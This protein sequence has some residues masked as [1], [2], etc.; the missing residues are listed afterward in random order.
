MLPEPCASCSVLVC[1]LLLSLVSFLSKINECMYVCIYFETSNWKALRLN[2]VLRNFRSVLHSSI[3]Q[4]SIKTKQIAD[5]Q[6]QYVR[7]EVWV[8]THSSW[9]GRISPAASGLSCV[10]VVSDNMLTDLVFQSVYTRMSSLSETQMSYICS[11]VSEF[12]WDTGWQLLTAVH[13]NVKAHLCHFANNTSSCFVHRAP[14]K[15]RHNI[16]H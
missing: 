7:V 3:L 11:T 15:P 1:L 13:D 2:S 16:Y 5:A 12:T 8:P 6:L 4:R 9:E 10:P 14:S